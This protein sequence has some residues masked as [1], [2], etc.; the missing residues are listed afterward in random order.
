MRPK[1]CV[2]CGAGLQWLTDAHR[3]VVALDM[4]PHPRGA[5]VI[6]RRRA[7][8]IETRFRRRGE[9]AY[10]L[11]GLSCVD[12]EPAFAVRQLEMFT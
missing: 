5:F 7:L 2:F 1:T 10:N 11:H 4:V 3:N 9:I 12:F 6:R 8:K